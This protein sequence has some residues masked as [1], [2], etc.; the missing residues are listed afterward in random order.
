M[1]MSDW[2]GGQSQGE[3]GWRREL[4]VQL[5]P[6]CSVSLLKSLVSLQ[7]LLSELG[8]LNI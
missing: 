4:A 6:H 8:G 7:E 5:L 2:V 3:E 1:M